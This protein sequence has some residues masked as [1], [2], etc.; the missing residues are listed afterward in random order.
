MKWSVLFPGF[1]VAAG[2]RPLRLFCYVTRTGAFLFFYV[3]KVVLR[4]GRN[5]SATP[6][7]DDVDTTR[8]RNPLFPV[9]GAMSISPSS[10]FTRH[11]RRSAISM[12]DVW[13]QR[14]A[15]KSS[16]FSTICSCDVGS[17][18]VSLEAFGYRPLPHLSNLLGKDWR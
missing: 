18:P 4:L 11:S 12:V 10:S 14:D 9:T 16:F 2:T 6:L 7:A 13:V 15:L 17:V 5:R 1:L 3:F 8:K